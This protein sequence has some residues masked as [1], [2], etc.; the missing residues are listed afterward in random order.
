MERPAPHT[1]TR[2]TLFA[3]S[4]LAVALALFIPLA[5][6]GSFSFD[7]PWVFLLTLG[8][9]VASWFQPQTTFLI[10]VAALPLVRSPQ[11]DVFSAE[12]IALLKTTW[13]LIWGFL[14]WLKQG[15]PRMK[16]NFPLGLRAY[17]IAGGFLITLSFLHAQKW[18]ESL[19]PLLIGATAGLLF[20]TLWNSK[21]M[22]H[23]RI[24]AVILGIAGSIAVLSVLQ[25]AMF[26]F[27]LFPQLWPYVLSP[28][29]QKYIQ[30][31]SSF[32][33]Q[34]VLYRVSGTFMHSNMLGMYLYVVTPFAFAALALRQLPRW[35][36]RALRVLCLLLL[37][38]LYTT[39]SRA[40]FLAVFLSLG[41]ISFYRGYRWL[42]GIATIGFL[43][44]LTLYI[45]N[46][47]AM[48]DYVLRVTRIDYGLSSREGV[49]R[50]GLELFQ[51]FPIWGVGPGNF[52]TQYFSHFGFFLFDNPMEI[53]EQ[54]SLWQTWG[55]KIVANYHAHNTYLQLLCEYGLFSL[56]LFLFSMGW[57][58]WTGHRRIRTLPPHTLGRVMSLGMTAFCISYLVAGFFDSYILFTQFG[59]LLLVAILGTLSLKSV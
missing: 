38:A 8:V 37:V 1:L 53:Q 23:Q 56:P 35:Q 11:N 58:I 30:L 47:D 5:F 55:D 44:F 41:Y 57:I 4:R 34:P 20:W 3:H 13:F 27:Q 42:G 39:N 45:F 22:L 52:S 25:Y 36:Y 28:R 32:S 31:I 15:L 40:A 9:A 33:L 6:L 49:W 48:N 29:E 17:F 16:T 21:A 14:G 7:R 24:F 59:L 46:P 19:P 12:S 2:L 10:L 43:G 18:S 26:H 54:V 51:R 50:H